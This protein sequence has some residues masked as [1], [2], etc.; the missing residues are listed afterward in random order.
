MNPGV[1]RLVRLDG[2]GCGCP[3]A[4]VL[5]HWLELSWGIS[6]R[7]SRDISWHDQ[8]DLLSDVVGSTIESNVERYLRTFS[9]RVLRR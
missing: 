1:K 8:Y 7:P 2:S 5:R 6:L 4:P 3:R 9:R